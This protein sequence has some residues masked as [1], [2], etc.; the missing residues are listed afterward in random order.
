MKGSELLH[1]KYVKG[2]DR[3]IQRRWARPWDTFSEGAAI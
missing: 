3:S 2:G 1:A